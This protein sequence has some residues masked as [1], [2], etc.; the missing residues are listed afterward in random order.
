MEYLIGYLVIAVAWFLIFSLVR[1]R[2]LNAVGI[3]LKPGIMDNLVL[4]VESILWPI[5]MLLIIIGMILF[6]F[7]GDE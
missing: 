7:T 6:A 4:V 5:Q 1:K 3:E 2:D